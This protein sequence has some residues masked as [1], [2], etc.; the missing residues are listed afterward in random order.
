LSWEDVLRMWLWKFSSFLEREFVGDTKNTEVTLPDRTITCKIEFASVVR[1]AQSLFKFWFLIL[2]ISF[3]PWFLTLFGFASW[4]FFG[5]LV[6]GSWIYLVLW[7]L[8]LGFSMV[9]TNPL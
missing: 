6:L 4:N 7:F 2:E 3:D 9:S 1:R 5:F 8:V